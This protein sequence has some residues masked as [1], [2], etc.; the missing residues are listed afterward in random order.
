MSQGM[1]NMNNETTRRTAERERRAV[2]R[3]AIWR[4]WV[5]GFGVP[6]GIMDAIAIGTA[7]KHRPHT[8]VRDVI[9]VVIFAGCACAVSY[10]AGHIMEEE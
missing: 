1:N 7:V 10:A 3:R 8:F 9:L 5:L 2:R 6:L 4:R